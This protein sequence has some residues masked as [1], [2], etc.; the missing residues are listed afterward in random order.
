MWQ[1]DD[2]PPSFPKVHKFLDHWRMNVEAVIK[3]IYLANS[4]ITN[5]KFIN[6]REILKH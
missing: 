2:L 4:L 1:F 6:A 3:D 5:S